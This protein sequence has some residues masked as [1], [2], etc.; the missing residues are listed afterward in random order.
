MAKSTWHEA[1]S[2]SMRTRFSKEDFK[3]YRSGIKNSL[4][5]YKKYISVGAKVLDLGCGLGCTSVPLSTF[6]F[7]ITGIDNDKNVVKAAK[8]NAKEFGNEIEILEGDA[9][10]IDTI[11]GKDSFDACISGGLLEHF[12]KTKI[13][14]LVE[15]Q[16][17]VAPLMIASMPVRTGA[18][19]KAYGARE[20]KGCV[21]V[22][23]EG[24]YRNFWDEE[25]WIK[26]ILKGFNIV[27]HFTEKADPSIGDFEEIM[28]VIKRKQSPD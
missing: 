14:E 2:R 28:I 1:F 11:F 25:T 27:E 24:I 13:R 17:F 21:H 20:E 10:E 18:T 16:L 26:D 6:G 9:F 4:D 12:D 3:K 23:K 22:D 15:K 5:F 19:L 7:R 8:H